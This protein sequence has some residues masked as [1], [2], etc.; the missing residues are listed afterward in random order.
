HALI[1]ELCGQQITGVEIVGDAEHAGS[2]EALRFHADPDEGADP[3]ASSEDIECRLRCVLAGVVAES[4]VSGRPR[5]DDTSGDLDVAVRLAMKLVDDCEDVLPLLEEVGADLGAEL[6]RRWA[7]VEL[8]AAE[9]LEHKRL[10][11]P[12]VRRILDLT[13]AG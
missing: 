3:R 10:S 5:W 9:L 6:E 4:M 11:G 8:L 7:A 1:A 13:A 12:E 2:T